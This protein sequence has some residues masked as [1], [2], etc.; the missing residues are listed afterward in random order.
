MSLEYASYRPAPIRP[1]HWVAS[2]SLGAIFGSMLG[3]IGAVTVTTLIT[4]RL[5]LIAVIFSGTLVTLT[6][7]HMV[8]YGRNGP[9]N[10]P[11]WCDFGLIA[12]VL[13]P[14]FI[15]SVIKAFWS[16]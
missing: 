11:N 3:S 2:F 5:A 1:T 13:F 6:V 4:G 10:G 7:V 12:G 8:K 16:R 9:K 15:A 14:I